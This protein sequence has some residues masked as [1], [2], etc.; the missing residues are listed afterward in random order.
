MDE[1]DELAE[2]TELSPTD[3]PGQVV[4]VD[5]AVEEISFDL[6][7]EVETLAQELSLEIPAENELA[8]IADAPEAELLVEDDSEGLETLE[9]LSAEALI[10]EAEG[11]PEDELSQMQDA[12]DL[13][14]P[15]ED[16]P[17][18]AAL[19]LDIPEEET[20]QDVLGVEGATRRSDGSPYQFDVLADV[21]ACERVACRSGHGHREDCFR[22]LGGTLVAYNAPSVARV[23]SST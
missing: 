14:L 20:A 1:A 18:E 12:I 19:V 23:D 5:E 22:C 10:P 13:E 15:P 11:V 16:E 17:V 2:L 4:P 6:G 3:E 9:E 21:A 8:D 7:D